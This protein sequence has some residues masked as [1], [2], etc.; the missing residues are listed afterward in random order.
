MRKMAEMEMQLTYRALDHYSEHDP[1]KLMELWPLC[2]RIL[3]PWH[4]VTLFS[5]LHALPLLNEE[6]AYKVRARLA[7]AGVDDALVQ[8]CAW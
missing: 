2:E 3:G 4:G 1:A 8:E 5:A 7:V 6:R